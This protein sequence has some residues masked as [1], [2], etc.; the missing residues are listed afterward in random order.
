M[1]LETWKQEFMPVPPRVAAKR[2]RCVALR[3]ELLMWQ[4]T[5]KRVLKEHQVK[6]SARVFTICD[7]TGQCVDL[8]FGPLCERYS[9][10]DCRY[11][12]LTFVRGQVRCG[13]TT[14]RELHSPL[15]AVQLG[16]TRPMRRLIEKAIRRFC[17]GY[18]EAETANQTQ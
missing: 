7:E 14:D 16:D 10:G 13:E 3:A 18:K 17:N 8:S 9:D 12:P 1:S 5:A 4:G 6:F 15:E 11:C 2:G